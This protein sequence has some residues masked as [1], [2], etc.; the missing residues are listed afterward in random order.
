MLRS[1]SAGT[2]WSL[3]RWDTV[4]PGTLGSCDSWDVGILWILGRCVICNPY[5]HWDL[6]F[7]GTLK[8]ELSGGRVYSLDLLWWRG[9]W[10]GCPPHVPLSTGPAHHFLSWKARS[11]MAAGT[12]HGSFEIS[13]RALLYGRPTSP[14][15][16]WIAKLARKI[17]WLAGE[18]RG[19]A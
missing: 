5:E 14:V 7:P 1:F 3:G 11:V 17:K 9:R 8:S 12:C 15:V 10:G 2:L 4:I 16:T 6:C 18:E 13:Q 19:D